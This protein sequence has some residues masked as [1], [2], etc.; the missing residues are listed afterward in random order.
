M[1]NTYF[2]QNTV[3]GGFGYSSLAA[4]ENACVMLLITSIR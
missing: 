2:S 4:A 3:D 1:S